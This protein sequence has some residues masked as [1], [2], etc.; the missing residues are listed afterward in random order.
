MSKTITIDINDE[1]HKFLMSKSDDPETVEIL[2]TEYLEQGI[3][4]KQTPRQQ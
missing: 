1:A 3:S 2:A 4:I